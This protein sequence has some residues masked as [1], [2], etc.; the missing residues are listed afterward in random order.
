MQVSFSYQNYTIK[1]PLYTTG[2]CRLFQKDQRGFLSI[3]RR[4]RGTP[5]I[6]IPELFFREI[7]FASRRTF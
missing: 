1:F 2:S 3:I 4:I 5:L 6:A 7:H